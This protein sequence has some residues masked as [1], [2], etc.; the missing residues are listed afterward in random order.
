METSDARKKAEALH[1]RVR[2]TMRTTLGA[3]AKIND[4][5]RS[6]AAELRERTHALGNV[7]AEL[8]AVEETDI[9]PIVEKVDAWGPQRRERM[10]EAH[11]NEE[12]AVAE[13]ERAAY[14]E[15]DPVELARVVLHAIREVLRALRW[16]EKYVI[17]PHLL[18]DDGIV[19]NQFGG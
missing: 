13:A 15:Q 19:I 16:E 17:H 7:L 14:E 10:H 12:A 5:D 11:D 18:R 2:E 3:I 8:V 9:G 1:E 6:A 4:G